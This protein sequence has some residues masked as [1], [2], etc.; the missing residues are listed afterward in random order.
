[1][2]K[3]KNMKQNDKGKNYMNMPTNKLNNCVCMAS[4]S[5]ML[6]ALANMIIGIERHS[7]NT[8]DQYVILHEVNEVF[9]E[10]D[11]MALTKLSNKIRFYPVDFKGIYTLPKLRI[12]SSS[13]QYVRIIFAKFFIFDL[14]KD[15]KHVLW[16]DTDMLVLKDISNLFKIEGA[17]WR[18]VRAN[19]V[20]RC[21]FIKN[22]V[23]AHNDAF[24]T[25]SDIF[26]PPS[27]GLIY[28]SDTI[29]NYANLTEKC[30]HILRDCYVSADK[31]TMAL[32]ELIIGI[33]NYTDNIEAQYIDNKY[34]FIPG[35]AKETE[36]VIIHSCGKKKFWNS[37]SQYSSYKEWG[38]NNNYWL[39]LGGRNIV[40]NIT[41]NK[42]NEIPSVGLLNFHFADNYGAVLD[43]FS[44]L[45]V[46]EDLGYKAEII[47]Y[48][49]RNAHI[50]SHKNFQDF[51][52]NFLNINERTPKLF[53]QQEL[54][55]RQKDF[56]KIIVGS[57]QVWRLFNSSIYMLNFAHGYKTLISYSASFG[58]DT[59]DSLP[60]DKAISLLNRFDAISVR[61]TSGV[62]I[63]SD[64]FGLPAIQTL[65][66]VF[67][68]DNVQYDEII[69]YYRPCKP[70]YKY[71]SYAMVNKKNILSPNNN[72][73]S[74]ETS[75]N[76][77]LKNILKNND[78]EEPNSVGGWLNDIKNS[79]F[80]ITDSYYATCFA[81]IYKKNFA[82][83][84]TDVNGKDRIPSLLKQLD[85]DT[86]ERIVTSFEQIDTELLNKNIDYS[87][88]YSKL[89]MLKSKSFLFLHNALDKSE[90]Y[91]ERLDC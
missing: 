46:I 83:I 12:L 77:K 9:N 24:D 41:F 68:L 86:S 51:R 20:P 39:S 5:Y 30:F 84:V 43:S 70:S 36:A 33:I 65:D 10:N 60:N 85:I 82:C 8:V 57:E 35:G 61:E 48:L 74:I 21:N 53:S 62:T 3:P 55:E 75:L 81:I 64:Q 16:L 71:I 56:N 25:N 34:N 72:V 80:V 50:H 15:Y 40:K 32:D 26:P 59:F 47:N 37:P 23:K 31:I 29:N 44:L 6:P 54:E 18:P 87:K 45:K 13:S 11:V 27:G 38:E 76:I 67:L 1:M 7:P 19:L 2:K 17:G 78:E 69:K 63:C 73:K 22:Y 79:S 49:P 4:S 14:L 88:V 42:K 28:V 90:N 89:E 58:N 52:G 91:K 66:P